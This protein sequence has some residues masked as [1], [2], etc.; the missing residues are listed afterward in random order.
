VR[1]EELV[2]SE[3]ASLVCPECG[4]ARTKRLLSQVS[5]SG[6]QARGARVRSDESRRR[7]R[8]A[9]RG[10]RLAESRSKRAKGDL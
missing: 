8:E 6:R 7:D 2:P 1:Y 4:S 10:E 5:P 9:A 3:T